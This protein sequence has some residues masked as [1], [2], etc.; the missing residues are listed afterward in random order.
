ME[1]KAE[2]GHNGLTPPVPNV[3]YMVSL[4]ILAEGAPALIEKVVQDCTTVLAGYSRYYEILIINN[5]GS[6]EV[7]QCI[8]GLLACVPN[9]RHLRVSRHCSKNIALTAALDH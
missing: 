4:A 6:S 2:V 1:E 5:L 9:L 3:D 7:D 8:D